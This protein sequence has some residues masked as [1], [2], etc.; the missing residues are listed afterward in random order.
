[1]APGA[2][3]W[4]LFMAVAVVLAA[5]LALRFYHLDY[6]FVTWQDTGYVAGFAKALGVAGL[7]DVGFLPLRYYDVH[8]GAYTYYVN[9]P[10]LVH[11]AL[12]VLFNIFGP[13]EWAY[14]SFN[15]LVGGVLGGVFL[16]R[17]VYERL[18]REVAFGA[19]ILWAFAPSTAYFERMYVMN[20]QALTFM[21]IFAFYFLRNWE[22]RRGFNHAGLFIAAVLGPLFDWHYNFVYVPL[23]LQLHYA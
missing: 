16:F 11:I 22:G 14:R 21:I 12:A 13:Q 9:H 4:R 20:M 10:P 7:W 17:L 19:L 2:I 8:T 3:A 15:L 23:F 18:G 6:G 1:M 5:A